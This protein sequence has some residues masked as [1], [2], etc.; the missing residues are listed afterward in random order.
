MQMANSAFDAVIPQEH[1]ST[2]DGA[3]ASKS[4]NAAPLSIPPIRL[5]GGVGASSP[6]KNNRPVEVQV[7]EDWAMRPSQDNRPVVTTFRPNRF[8]SY[9]AAKCPCS[10]WAI[11]ARPG[12]VV[13]ARLATKRAIWQGIRRGEPV[14]LPGRALRRTIERIDDGL[15]NS[16]TFCAQFFES[17]LGNSVERLHGRGKFLE[18]GR[19]DERG[20]QSTSQNRCPIAVDAGHARLRLSAHPFVAVLDGERCRWVDVGKPPAQFLMGC[21]AKCERGE[22]QFAGQSR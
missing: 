1:D 6:R 22:P 17:G 2:G 5:A 16:G 10:S 18:T 15:R 20:S 7:I 21:S 19:G 8:S 4:Y 13:L 12:S 11:V 3:R 14:G 9:R